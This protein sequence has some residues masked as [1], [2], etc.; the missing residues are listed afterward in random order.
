MPVTK[1]FVGLGLICG[2]PG[3]LAVGKLGGNRNV[4]LAAWEAWVTLHIAFS[5]AAYRLKGISSKASS[6]QCTAGAARMHENSSGWLE[7]AM[8]VL[9][10]LALPVLA[11][12]L[13]FRW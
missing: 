13:P 10:G 5:T 12:T 3:Y 4:W 2:L 6:R 8:W 9:L 11:G 7:A 1:L